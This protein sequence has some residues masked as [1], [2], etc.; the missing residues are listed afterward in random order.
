MSKALNSALGLDMSEVAQLLRKKGRGKDTVLAHITPKEAALLKRRGGRGSINPNTGLPEFDDSEFG[1]VDNFDSGYTPVDSYGGG[2]TDWGNGG[3]VPMNINIPQQ[4]AG[5]SSTVDWSQQYDPSQAGQGGVAPELSGYSAPAPSADASYD[6]FGN[7]VQQGSAAATSADVMSPNAPASQ[8]QDYNA[9]PAAS[10]AAGGGAQQGSGSGWL[11]TLASALG[12]TVAGLAKAGVLSGTA[13]LGAAQGQQSAAQGQKAADQ[14]GALAP[15]AANRGT[16]AATGLANIAAATQQAGNAASQA[17]SAVGQPIK[18]VGTTM[19]QT[20]QGGG[21]TPAD[22]QALDILRARGLQD[23]SKRGGV[24]AMQEGVAESSARST[25]G[26][27][28]LDQALAT[29]NQGAQY[30]LAAQQIKLAQDNLAS[31]YYSSAIS[32]AMSQANFSDGYTTQAIMLALQNDQVTAQ[33]LQKLYS[34]LAS[35][36]FG[37]GTGNGAITINTTPAAPTT[38]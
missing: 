30:D 14:V 2:G 18:D 24:G 16:V 13:A 7:P 8:F 21:L 36:A 38:T 3:G 35:I 19:L 22:L 11:Q 27:R 28:E 37:G 34:S 9:P 33:N 17:V 23:I 10:P 6:S 4:Q 25:M 20:A 15:V 26:Q 5:P 12:T 1:F 32:T 31:Q 29:Y